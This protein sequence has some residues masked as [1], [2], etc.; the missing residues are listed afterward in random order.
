[1]LALP[2][3]CAMSDTLSSVSESSLL[4]YCQ[5]QVTP[6]VVHHPFFTFEF[7]AQVW[8]FKRIF[9][10]PFPQFLFFLAVFIFQDPDILR[11]YRSKRWFWHVYEDWKMWKIQVQIFSLDISDLL[12]S[13]LGVLFPQLHSLLV[14]CLHVEH[15][16]FPAPGT[17]PECPLP[18]LIQPSRPTSLGLLREAH[19]P[20]HW[21]RTSLSS[22][23]T[24][25]V[26]GL[27][28]CDIS[29][30]HGPLSFPWLELVWN[31]WFLWLP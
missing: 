16:G 10:C 14:T 20:R 17:C 31:L 12:A 7:A 29:S 18:S 21:V 15:Q 2:A 13:D 19:G 1:M 24:V 4:V 3:A 5:R 25:L 28:M 9:S 11:K 23:N 22:L 6:F 26:Q 8:S 30:S 27:V